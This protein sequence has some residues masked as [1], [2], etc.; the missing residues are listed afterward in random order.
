MDACPS[1]ASSESVSCVRC[2]AS[3]QEV[4][5]E[6]KEGFFSVF[7]KKALNGGSDLFKNSSLVVEPAQ[8]EWPVEQ[9]LQGLSWHKQCVT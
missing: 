9:K 3:E 6:E 2:S 8:S 1:G 5:K 7:L 4:K